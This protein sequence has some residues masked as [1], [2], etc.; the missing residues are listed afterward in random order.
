M[1]GPIAFGLSWPDRI[2]NGSAALD[3]KTLSAM[4]FEAVDADDHADRFPGLLLAWQVLR[5]PS[6]TPAVLNAANEVAVQA[7]L[8]HRIRFDQIHAVNLATLSEVLPSKPGTLDDLLTI[9][10]M[11]RR[12][13]LGHVTRMEV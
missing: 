1:R 4:T 2:A 10:A 12:A 5:A 9:D 13:A 8:D 7:F 6:G 11:S 3:F